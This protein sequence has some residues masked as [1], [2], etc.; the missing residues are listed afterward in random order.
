MFHALSIIFN[1][2]IYIYIKINWLLHKSL[3]AQ[4][5]NGA[6]SEDR[7]TG[8]LYSGHVYSYSHAQTP[9]SSR[10]EGLGTRLVWSCHDYFKLQ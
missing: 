8:G 6:H 1:N 4:L 3:I 7:V 10:E 2:L 5:P 9:P